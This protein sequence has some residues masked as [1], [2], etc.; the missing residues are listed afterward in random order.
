[1]YGHTVGMPLQY[2]ESA[3]HG[4]IVHRGADLADTSAYR[5]NYLTAHIS[6]RFPVSV[7]VSPGKKCLV[8]GNHFPRIQYRLIQITGSNLNILNPV[9]RAAFKTGGAASFKGIFI[10]GHFFRNV[11]HGQFQVCFLQYRSL[12][13]H[14]CAC[15]YLQQ[16]M[17]YFLLAGGVDLIVRDAGICLY[18]IACPVIII[19]GFPLRRYTGKRGIDIR[20]KSIQSRCIRNMTQSGA[21][22][23]V[24]YHYGCITQLRHHLLKCIIPCLY[25]K[26]LRRCIRLQLSDGCPV[27]Y[28]NGNLLGMCG[29]PC[30]A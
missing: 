10:D 1:M 7:G 4:S 20:N 22:S 21:V 30:A 5:G 16:C 27:G 28:A 6:P 8:H 15:Q 24:L 18:R 9:G 19:K 25:H 13:V 2:G 17:V 23:N 26:T 11:S 12:V 14:S 3:V 29:Q